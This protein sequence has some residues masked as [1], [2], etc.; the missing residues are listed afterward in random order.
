MH[1]DD[2]GVLLVELVGQ[3]A[4]LIAFVLRDLLD[5]GLLIDPQHRLH[6]PW[7]FSDFENKTVEQTHLNLLLGDRVGERLS[8]PLAMRE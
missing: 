7:L 3:S 8:N 2:V 6:F 5:K 4:L 1:A